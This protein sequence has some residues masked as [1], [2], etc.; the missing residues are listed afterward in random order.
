MGRFDIPASIDYVLNVTGQSKLAAYYGYSLGC[1]T[2]Y[3]AA[4]TQPR[5][6]EKVELMVALGP[7][8]S[9][10]NLKNFLR[11]LAPFANVYQVCTSFTNFCTSSRSLAKDSQN[12]SILLW[13]LHGKFPM[14]QRM[15]IGKHR[16]IR[17]SNRLSNSLIAIIPHLL[18]NKLGKT[19]LP[20]YQLTFN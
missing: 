14:V 17:L 4:I 20:L 15:V 8:V 18:R 5:M 12:D 19:L 11:Y 3:I 16:K 2:F 9:V 10:A 13:S 6:N 7:T 1:S